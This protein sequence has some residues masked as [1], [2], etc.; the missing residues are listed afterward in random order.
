MRHSNQLRSVMHRE[1]FSLWRGS[2]CFG[3]CNFNVPHVKVLS[4]I[5]IFL[6]IFNV[7]YFSF[8]QLDDA[9]IQVYKDGDFG[10]YL[11][12]ESSLAE[13]SEEIEGLNSRQAHTHDGLCNAL[14]CMM[15]HNRQQPIILSI[16]HLFG[17]RE[18]KCN[19]RHTNMMMYN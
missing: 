14:C 4:S 8:S 12:L 6:M 11:D 16:Y 1:N 2:S 10:A 19:N 15:L 9:S 5:L 3:L 7:F 18:R 13:Q 17:G